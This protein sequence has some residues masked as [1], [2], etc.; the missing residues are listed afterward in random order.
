MAKQEDSDDDMQDAL[1]ANL[2]ENSVEMRD[3]ATLQVTSSI[4]VDTADD[5]RV[6]I[7]KLSE[8]LS[9]VGIN[10]SRTR[11]PE[12]HDADYELNNRDTFE[13][14]SIVVGAAPPDQL[15]Y[16]VLR[17]FRMGSRVVH[18]DKTSH[19]HEDVKTWA[20]TLMNCLSLAKEEA[21]M[22]LNRMNSQDHVS[23]KYVTCGQSCVFKWDDCCTSDSY[24]VE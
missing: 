7:K 16:E 22:R 1:E 14:L 15:H 11:L 12:K 23:D 18:P 20:N 3:I 9:N 8:R 19:F 24:P 4:A 5:N 13:F 6:I 17:K 10:P 21:L 2:P